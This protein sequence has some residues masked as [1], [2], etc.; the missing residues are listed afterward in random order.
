ML[1]MSS[2][3]KTFV[4]GGYETRALDGLHF[5]VEEGGF[6]AVVGP[7]GSGKSTLLNIAGLLDEADSGSYL[8]DGLDVSRLSDN[9]RSEVRNRKIGFIF[10]AFNLV[11]DCNVFHNVE[12]PLRYRG[13][14][15]RSRK[16]LVDSALERV[17]LASRRNH[18][19][20]E[21]SGGQ[22]QRAAIARA[23]VGEPRV[24]LADEPTGNLDTEMAEGVMQL[25]Q[26]AHMAGTTIVMVT[27][28]LQLARRA[29]RCVQIVDG[30]LTD[31]EPELTPC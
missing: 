12:I 26:E 20:R 3:S 14:D 6:V 1:E 27:H 2:V 31:A 5:H 7:S 10:Q 25:L 4:A 19:P 8:L 16:A 23:L 9:A 24:I 17:G 13:L 29:Q 28:D 18:L 30:V 15:R 11:P 22:Q 21:L